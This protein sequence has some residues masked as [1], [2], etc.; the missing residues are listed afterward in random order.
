MLVQARLNLRVPACHS[1]RLLA[2]H[3]ER[4]QE[5]HAQNDKSTLDEY[6]GFPS[7]TALCMHERL[8]RLPYPHLVVHR[9]NPLAIGRP[10]QRTYQ[11]RAALIGKDRLSQLLHSRPAQWYPRIQKLDGYHQ[12][13]TPMLDSVCMPVIGE[14]ALTCRGIPN[15]HGIIHAT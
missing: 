2:C 8:A 1:E 4:E 10:G 7:Y 15:L 6:N 5:S 13:T 9:S 3:S 14:I 11:V 12:A